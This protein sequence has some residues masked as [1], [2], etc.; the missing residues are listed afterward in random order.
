[1]T[2]ISVDPVERLKG[3]CDPATPDVTQA[4][5]AERI[6]ISPQ[7]LSEILKGKRNPS[8][9]VLDFLELEKVVS[10]QPREAAHAPVGRWPARPGQKRR[11]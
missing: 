6:G 7:F 3:L 2:H 1:M 4:A 11:A 5:L 9:T 8:K 10:Y